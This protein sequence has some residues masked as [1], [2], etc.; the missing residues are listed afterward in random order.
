MDQTLDT[1]KMLKIF[2]GDQVTYESPNK[3]TN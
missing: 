3:I 2:Q 1:L